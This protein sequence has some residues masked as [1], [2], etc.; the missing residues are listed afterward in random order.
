[1]RSPEFAAGATGIAC[2]AACSGEQ[3]AR[4]PARATMVST[5]PFGMSVRL[6]LPSSK[7]AGIQVYK[8]RCAIVSDAAASQA[9]GVHGKSRAIDAGHA[10]IDGAPFHM[11]TLPGDTAALLTQLR[12]G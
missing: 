6:T 7:R 11:Q 9:L 5:F 8:I 2:G 3:A 4:A 1:M 10:H 12:I